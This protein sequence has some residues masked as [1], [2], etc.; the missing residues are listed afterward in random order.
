M[1]L[2]ITLEFH[3]SHLS[4]LF[5]LPSA[6]KSLFFG[7]QCTCTNL[8]PPCKHEKRSRLSSHEKPQGE[9]LSYLNQAWLTM[10]TGWNKQV[11][12][13]FSCAPL[14]ETISWHTTHTY[15]HK[16]WLETESQKARLKANP[17][18]GI[19]IRH[20][21]CPSDHCSASPII[22]KLCGLQPSSHRECLASNKCGDLTFQT[23]EVSSSIHMG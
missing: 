10:L 6:D 11:S 23:P 13:L 20:L 4:Q 15:I 1:M 8:P 16:K 3:V 19:C 17:A 5:S 18:V 7:S 12:P 22:S 2:S 14:L 9:D 21:Q